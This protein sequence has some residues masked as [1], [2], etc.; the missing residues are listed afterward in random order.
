M[1][2][3]DPL[4]AEAARG[5]A[6]QIVPIS[7][8][9]EATLRILMNSV[10]FLMGAA[11]VRQPPGADGVVASVGRMPWLHD[12]R[13]TTL[14]LPD[15]AL[16]A[17]R[18]VALDWP[19][20]FQAEWVGAPPRLVISRLTFQ[21]RTVGVLLGTLV[22]REPFGQQTREALDLSCELIASAVAGES[23]MAM[24]APPPAPEAEHHAPEPVA[25][26]EQPRPE[27]APQ[28][29][30]RATIPS[31]QI[32]EEVRR[33]LAAAGDARSLGRVLRD[34]M[35]VITDA[36]AFSV[37]LF[38]LTRPEVA[39]RYKV[40]GPDR[41][42]AE[43]GRQHVDDGPAC[44]AAR[45]DRRWHV[46]A[47]DLAIRDELDVRIR[48]VIVLQVPMTSS[49][50]VFGIVTV[51][52]FRPEGFT[53]QALRL[54]ATVVEASVPSFAQVR[55][56]G[57]F[58]PAGAPAQVAAAPSAPPST[59]SGAEPAA[60][61]AEEVA[62]DLLRRCGGAGF[63]T[64]FIVGVD[65]GAGAVRGELVSEGDA[66]REIDYALGVSSG[67]FKVPLDDR[68]NAIARAVREARIVP[69]PTA[70]EITRPAADVEAARSIERLVGGGRSVTLPLVVSGEVA[71]ALVLG[72]MA[73]DPSFVAIETIRGYVEDAVRELSALWAPAD[74]QAG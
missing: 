6:L 66:A 47:R 54:V 17:N 72:P 58:Q 71:G 5:P 27:P 61:G 68:Y 60:R 30:P 12:R 24:A 41:D 29:E 45:H 51:Q 64:A 48:E 46:F 7:P 28:P 44:Y 38:H 13:L 1:A 3:P 33:G 26:A 2:I 63:P 74:G 39:Y 65:P 31:D 10:P 19:V 73:D 70:Y 23:A 15:D 53:D 25:P 22:T 32:V 69:A 11:V 16:P 52:T 67:K 35:S 37:A 57:R 59:P 34:A 9:V 49:G 42:S 8:P 20:P 43:L 56:T 50:E 18:A 4:S 62:R 36:S 40:V 21:G 55:S 14:Q